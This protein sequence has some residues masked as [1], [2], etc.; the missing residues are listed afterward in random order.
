MSSLNVWDNYTWT[1]ARE[2]Q[3]CASSYEPTSK[4]FAGEMQIT[5]DVLQS[6]FGRYSRRFF[7]NESI[8]S[9]DINYILNFVQ[10]D[11]CRYPYLGLYMIDQAKETPKSGVYRLDDTG[12]MIK[13]G[14]T[15]RKKLI[16]DSLQGM[17]WYSGGLSFYLVADLDCVFNSNCKA[18]VYMDMLIS[19]GIVAQSIIMAGY[20]RG[21][22]GWM[23]PAVNEDI[24]KQL[25]DIKSSTYE[26]LY[27]IKLGHP[28][29]RDAI[30]SRY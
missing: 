28:D 20:A 25:L 8:S 24:A 23:S 1:R 5:E 30:E 13:V 19:L 2:I 29:G 15:Y 7:T 9:D 12:K 10:E 17:W 22:G 4:P 16:L 18:N 6:A 11:I 26:P 27:Y 21:L 14:E 3:F